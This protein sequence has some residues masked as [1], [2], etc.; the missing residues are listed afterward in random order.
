MD[1]GWVRELGLLDKDSDLIAVANCAEYASV[2]MEYIPLGVGLPAH[3]VADMPLIQP[4][5]G[6][7]LVKDLTAN[8]W[9]AVEDYRHG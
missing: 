5:T 7:A 4:K 8:Q 1:G 6:M 9:I 2:G 3:S